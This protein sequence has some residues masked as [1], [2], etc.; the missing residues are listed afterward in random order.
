MYDN[1]VLNRTVF[2]FL[3]LEDLSESEKYYLAKENIKKIFGFMWS[4]F[5]E[6]PDMLFFTH[7]VSISLL[8]NANC[9]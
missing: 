6:I 2:T 1:E 3:Q 9:I 5:S 8:F 4:L 7:Q